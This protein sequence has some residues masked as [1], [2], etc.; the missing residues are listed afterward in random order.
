MDIAVQLKE[1]FGSHA[2]F[3]QDNVDFRERSKKN[4]LFL[5]IPARYLNVDGRR[6]STTKDSSNTTSTNSSDI[7]SNDLFSATMVTKDNTKGNTKKKSKRET[8]RQLHVVKDTAPELPF[9]LPE[10]WE[11]VVQQHPKT[12][13]KFWIAPSGK[14]YRSLVH[15]KEVLKQQERKQVTSLNVDVR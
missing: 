14:R 10:G 9:V 1:T 3:E 15:V 6:S 2:Q 12:V 11:V 13:S 8:T 5:S 4:D 7:S